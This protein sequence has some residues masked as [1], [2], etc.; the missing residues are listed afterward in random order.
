MSSRTLTASAASWSSSAASVSPAVVSS[1]TV[2]V[3]ALMSFQLERERPAV[4]LLV[5]PEHLRALHVVH[6]RLADVLDHLGGVGMG[7]PVQE[8]ARLVALD[9]PPQ[10]VVAHVRRV[11]G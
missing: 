5:Q 1:R 9:P 2:S 10:P 7:V 11:V 6:A 3:I 4:A 8:V